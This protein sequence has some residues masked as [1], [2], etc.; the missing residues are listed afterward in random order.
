MPRRI[1]DISVAL[2][3]DITSDAGIPAKIE[4]AA[5]MARAVA[6]IED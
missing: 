3:T 5:G 6:I 2:K 4:A 1:I